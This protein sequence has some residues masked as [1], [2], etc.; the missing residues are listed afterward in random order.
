MIKTNRNDVKS[1]CLNILQARTGTA[2]QTVTMR[3]KCDSNPG[4]DIVKAVGTIVQQQCLGMSSSGRLPLKKRLRWGGG[5][6]GGNL[7]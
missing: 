6:H 2:W 1:A 5:G 7:L 3:T 4:G